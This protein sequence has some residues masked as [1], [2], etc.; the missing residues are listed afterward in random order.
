VS[1]N[2]QEIQ[3]CCRCLLSPDGLRLTD[4]IG[5][6]SHQH[7]AILV[8]ALGWCRVFLDPRFALEQV[9]PARF[10]KPRNPRCFC[11]GRVL[12]LQPLGEV[13]PEAFKV[14]FYSP[15]AHRAT[16][17]ENT[18]ERAAIMVSVCGLEPYGASGNPQCHHD[19]TALFGQSGGTVAHRLLPSGKL[20]SCLLA[21]VPQVEPP[22]RTHA[23]RSAPAS[24]C[25]PVLT[26]SFLHP[27]S[28]PK[29]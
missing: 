8:P 12:L 24:R 10:S 5:Q 29:R 3:V 14:T 16:W 17:P 19:E 28:N 18:D 23:F 26:V 13:I 4:H 27:H 22:C 2:D 9:L 21:T 15:P 7:S 25:P 11:T 6:R 1:D 20:S